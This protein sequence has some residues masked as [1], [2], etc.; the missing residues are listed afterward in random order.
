MSS[1]ARL[2]PPA[3]LAL[4]LVLG[5]CSPSAA[6]PS[7]P[8][9]SAVS[10]VAFHGTGQALVDVLTTQG[11]TCDPESTGPL[12]TSGTAADKVYGRVCGDAPQD[13]PVTRLYLY[14]L[15]SDG[16]L[17]GLS[18]FISGRVTDPAWAQAAAQKLTS[19]LALVFP[20]PAVAVISAAITESAG[21]GQPRAVS[22]SVRVINLSP[23]QD[24]NTL[25]EIWGPE[26]VAADAV[27]LSPA[28]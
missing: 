7:T 1:T 25:V 3:L 16:S 20:A 26:V 12:P 22:P 8:S 6:T 15:R 9:A 10:T 19:D 4:I 18:I 23:S 28:P 17:A 5:A 27:T 21:D 14:E 11:F 2:A 24:G 13:G